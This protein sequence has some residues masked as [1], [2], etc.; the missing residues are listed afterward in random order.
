[1][2]VWGIYFKVG[3]DLIG[4]LQPT[5]ARGNRYIITSMDYGS[6]WAEA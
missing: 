4:P 1:M 3:L 5:T 6:K 2:P